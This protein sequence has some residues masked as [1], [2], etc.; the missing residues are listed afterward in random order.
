[1]SALPPKADIGPACR[2]VRFVPTADIHRVLSGPPVG[3]GSEP[4]NYADLNERGVL[5][6]R[7]G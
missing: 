2:D 1:M 5:T 3:S 4:R 6:H 7:A